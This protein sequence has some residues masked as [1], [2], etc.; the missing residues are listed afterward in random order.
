[1]NPFSYGENAG[2]VVTRAFTGTTTGNHSCIQNSAFTQ[3]D[4]YSLTPVNT[5]CASSGSTNLWITFGVKG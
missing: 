5:G 2:N 1:M 4:F 3:V